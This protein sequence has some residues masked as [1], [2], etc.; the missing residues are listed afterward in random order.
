M[1]KRGFRV[2]L[3]NVQ[4][5][6]GIQLVKSLLA[7]MDGRPGV[8]L[9]EAY[10]PAAGELADFQSRSRVARLVHYRR[11]LPNGLSRILECLVLSRSFDGDTPLLVLGDLPL[12]CEGKQILFLQNRFL[13]DGDSSSTLLFLLK[14]LVSRVIF[15]LNKRR[16]AYFIVQTE[17][18]KSALLKKYSLHAAQVGVIGQPP[19]DWLLASGL[20]RAAASARRGGALNLMYPADGYP[21]KNHKL[22]SRINSADSGDWKIAKLTLTVAAKHNPNPA[23]PWLECVG[24]QSTAEVLRRYATTDGL[25][26]LS[27]KESYGLPLVEAMWI[28]LPIVCADL[29]YARIL[30]GDGAI[31]FDPDDVKS[32]RRAINVLHDR[33]DSG[34][35]PDWSRQLAAVP[36]SWDDVA[37]SVLT[38]MFR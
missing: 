26:F 20:R 27:K 36:K 16:A 24:V 11:G 12:R 9:R 25:V 4:G 1:E 29:P 15:A 8:E 7:A 23:L 30:C 2:H 18:M 33:L 22:L 19:P 10:L 31:Y 21:H 34:W 37:S 5:L 14:T 32:L 3:T 28:G 6:G 38:A 35:W 13:L 17:L